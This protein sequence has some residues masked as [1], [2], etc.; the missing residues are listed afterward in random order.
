MSVLT[1]KQPL[2]TADKL[3]AQA[4]SAVAPVTAKVG[5]AAG[6]A[7]PLA[8]QAAQQA[9]PIARSAG[10]SVRQG[11]DGAIAWVTPYVDTARSWAAPQIEQSARA[12]S[13]S[14]APAI[15]NALVSAA[16]KIDAAPQQ[17]SGMRRKLTAAAL[18]TALAGAVTVIAMRLRH[19]ADN[20]AA[21]TAMP[22]PASK[23]G[24]DGE[25][26]PD[27]DMNGH[28]RIV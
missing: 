11:A 17:Q 20:F 6:R 14:V 22:E 27:P 13:D 5:P 8:Q 23:P 16:H 19:H 28:S 4:A 18:L 10:N 2:S 26:G 24:P 21:A 9:M 15:S 25:D 7:V 1:R 3:R 12:F